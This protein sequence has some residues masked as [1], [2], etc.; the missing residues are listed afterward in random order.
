M[1]AFKFDDF[2]Q[3]T[4]AGASNISDQS[5]LKTEQVERITSFLTSPAS[6]PSDN[7][8]YADFLEH[9]L[10]EYPPEPTE[11]KDYIAFS[12]TDRANEQIH[13]R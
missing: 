11:G 9:K 7:T 13:I 1:S 4:L 6:G 3:T 12:G 2:A 8:S 5:T 10:K